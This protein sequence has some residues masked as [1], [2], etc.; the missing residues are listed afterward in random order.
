MSVY[1][2]LSRV[3]FV[4]Q[5]SVKKSSDFHQHNVVL[6]WFYYFCVYDINYDGYLGRMCNEKA[7]VCSEKI[8]SR[9]D[10]NLMNV[11]ILL[12]RDEE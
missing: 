5:I 8:N 7:P 4:F 3:L 9:L 1:V 12:G 2:S 6:T 10:V 11:G